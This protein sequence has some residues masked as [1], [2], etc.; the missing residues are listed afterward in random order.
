MLVSLTIKN[1][2]LI[3]EANLIF[4]DGFTVITGETGAGKS[5]LL[6]A[7]GLITGKRADSSSV[8]DTSQKCIIEGAFSI[9]SYQLDIFFK[10]HD[11]DYEPTTIIRRELMPSGKSRAF[12]NDTPVTLQQLQILGERLIDIHSQH[13]TLEV[14]DTVYQF[15]IIDTFA[16]TQDLLKSYSKQYTAWKHALNQLEEV[17]EVKKKAQLEYD[18]QSFL[19]QEL[20][21]ASLIDG[22]FDTLEDQLKTLSHAEEIN[23]GL[24]EAQQRIGQERLGVLDILAEVRGSLN[25]LVAYG[26]DYE[27]LYVRINSSF[28]E[29]QDVYGELDQ[30]LGKVL[31]DPKELERINGRIQQ[32]YNLMQKHHVQDVSS[33]IQKREEL[34]NVLYEIHNVDSKIEVLEKEIAFAKAGAEKTALA[35]LKKRKIAIPKLVASLEKILVSLGMPNAQLQITLE[36]AEALNARGGGVLQFLFSANKGME[37]KSLK[38]GASGGELSRVMLAVKAVLSKHKK[39]PSLIFD[40]IDTGVSG[41]TALKMGSILKD[42]GNTMQLFSITHLP[43]IAGQGTSHFKVFKT[44]DENKTATQITALSQDQRIVE[45]AKML[46]GA[47]GGTTALEHAKN[48]LN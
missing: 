28:L 7:L 48:L 2:A 42:M 13:R 45:I 4:K 29:L 23:E 31:S 21:E 26:S 41:E 36:Q 40:E 39:L 46:G 27:Q 10:T 19:F 24:V 34:D 20:E 25:K 38:K 14:L 15:D 37:P 11:L 32:L 16:G 3:Q 43:Q 44:D 47:Q 12:I 30:M 18:Y 9:E 5:I 22:E 1:Y 35:L 17:V 6:G 33:L 8:G